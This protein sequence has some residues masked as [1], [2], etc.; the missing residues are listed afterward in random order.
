M[1][2]SGRLFAADFRG[3]TRIRNKERQEAGIRTIKSKRL[4]LSFQVYLFLLPFLF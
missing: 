2:S 3:Q 1:K 4:P